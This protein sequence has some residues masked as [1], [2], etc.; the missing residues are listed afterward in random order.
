VLYQRIAAAKQRNP[1][2]K[3]V[4]IDPRRTATCELAD[5]HLALAPGTDVWL[6]NGLLVHLFAH[7]AAEFAYLEAHTEGY[8]AALAAA[9]AS[10]PS[11]PAVARACGLADDDVAAFFNLY[12]CVEKTV[13]LYS[14]GVNQSSSGTDKVN[15]II[16][17]H[18]ATGRIGRPGMGPFSL[19]GQPNAM[20]GREVG[21]LA[22]Q[23]AAHMDLESADDRS[24]VQRFW[25]A[26]AVAS[27]PGLKAV[28]LFRAVEAGRIKALWIMATNPAVS[29]PDAAQ[30]RR[31]L[32]ACELVVVSDCVR[33]T[34]T[35]RYAHVLLPAAAWGEKDGTV[36][37]SERR[38]SRCR[39]FLPAPGQARP[40]WWIVK[41]VARRMG[42]A[43]AF[44]YRTAADVFREHAALSGFENDGA[45]DFDISGLAALTD[46]AY[47]ALAPVQW[48]IAPG[49]RGG[50]RF[51]GNGGFFTASA[52]A[53]LIALTPRPPAHAP[54]DEFPFV[55]NTG[56]TR[57]H[58]HT[59]T[60]TGKSARLSQHTAEPLG[61]L[62]PLDAAALGTN[63][64]DL[65]WV[66][67]RWGEAVA[68]VRTGDA[69]RRGSVFVPI[70]WN[71]RFASHGLVNAAV[72]PAFDPVSGQ[73]ECKHTPI[74]L[75]PCRFAWFGFVLARTEPHLRDVDYA[76][77][78][79]GAQF[80]RYELAGAAAPRDWAVYVRSWFDTVAG[81]EWLDFRDT[82]A[83][84]YRGALVAN[85]RLE[86][87][88]FIASTP[89]LP[90][91]A[92]L[93]ELF[94]RAP[95][96]S[97]ERASLLAGRPPGANTEGRAVCVCFGVGE[98]AIARAIRAQGLTSVAQIGA[99]LKAGTNCGSCIPELQALLAQ[100]QPVHAT[101]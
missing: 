79:V 86:A 45:R 90:E 31:A 43:A 68:R 44:D 48:P 64:G 77:K 91:R 65:V 70:H 101:G 37:N 85:D 97:A 55:L 32:E 2:V 29:L 23:L 93:A 7:G 62:H 9:R 67:S 100:V 50:A 46:A 8:A 51:F 41:E 78:S 63:D 54:D 96:S 27:R 4:V 12:A 99:Q 22:N 60:R 52:K 72:N 84:R 59:L 35:T 30:I 49:A 20:G 17:C 57:D 3:I 98:N 53:H 19:T 16:N 94:T 40:D 36:T 14:Q 58:W 33:D 87:C 61:E 39:A 5:L 26:P 73:P 71:R 21:G 56:R 76:V 66:R 82:A 38:I 6:W 34:D 74:R 69:Q 25:H 15:A 24:R 81:G 18:L 11:V 28:E 42:F 89:Q 13:T 10:S 83:G 75:E 80:L 1:R 92:W 95:L 47:D 88:V